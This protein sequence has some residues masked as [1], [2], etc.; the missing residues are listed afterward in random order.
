[1]MK[2]Y[3]WL[4]LTLLVLAFTACSET[5][6]EESEYSNWKSRNENYF[7]MM[8]NTAHD[9]IKY[10]KDQY[11]TAWEEQCNWRTYLSYSQQVDTT[12]ITADSICVQ[13]LRRGSGLGTSPLA[14]DSVRINYRTML[15]YTKEHP[16]GL[17]VDHSGLFSSFESVFDRN[18]ARPST[19]KVSALCRG[20]ATALLYMK[21][22]DLWRL[23][24]PSQLA[25]GTKKQGSI[26]AHS[27]LVF[28]MDLV[29]T[30]P[31]GT[32]PTPWH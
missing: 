20:V 32:T 14:T 11:G 12:H 27:T 22:G 9:S 28:E 16:A 15:I 7:Q 4:P 21:P 17:V 8:M 23:Y 1:M 29:D 5:D 24:M 26:P 31:M 2:K 10:A 18:I 25:Y 30:W 6:D 13:I 3:L 19:F